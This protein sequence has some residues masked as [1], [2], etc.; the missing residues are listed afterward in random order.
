MGYAK[1]VW[2]VVYE[3]QLINFCYQRYYI[4]CTHVCVKPIESTA[5]GLNS[6]GLVPTPT[7]VNLLV[8]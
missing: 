8:S 6:I 3:L 7:I 5:D 4:T 2:T 1:K